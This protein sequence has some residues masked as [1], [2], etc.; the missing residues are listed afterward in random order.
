MPSKLNTDKLTACPE[1]D[2]LMDTSEQVKEGYVS[3]CPRCSYTLE[4]PMRL[5]IR[6]N[7]FCV[8]IGL[9]FY[10]PA[11]LLPIMTFTMIGT[12]RPMSILDALRTLVVTGNM[13]IAAL[14]LITLVLIPLLKM[15]LIIF[16]T[17]RLYYRAQT[18]YLAASFKW[19][20]V[21]KSWGMLDIFMLSLLVSAIKLSDDAELLPGLGL[22]AFVTLLLS[23]ALQTQLLNKKLLWR[24]IERHGD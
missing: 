24:L 16:I 5:S 11:M 3:E 15:I 14:F 12:T 10:F 13:G 20:N 21:I 18:H 19:Y 9:I 23:S 7:F 17:T 4:H 2:L 6:H 1:C 22:Y 8:I